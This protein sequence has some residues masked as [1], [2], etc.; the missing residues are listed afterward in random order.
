GVLVNAVKAGDGH[1]SPRRGGRPVSFNRHLSYPPLRHVLEDLDV[2]RVRAEL[3]DALLPGPGVALG[4]RA[5]ALFIA[6]DGRR[7]YLDYGHV[8]DLLNGLLDLNLVRVLR[9]LEGVLL[10]V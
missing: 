4:I 7:G 8:E 9:N 2:L 1:R 10:Y 6:L 5:S 3:H